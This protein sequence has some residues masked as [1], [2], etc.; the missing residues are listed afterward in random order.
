MAGGLQRLSRPDHHLLP[1]GR[2]IRDVHRH[3]RA[4]QQLIGTDCRR[5]GL[6][7]A[8]EITKLGQGNFIV[9]TRRGPAELQMGQRIA[10]DDAPDGFEDRPTVAVALMKS[11]NIG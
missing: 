5:I 4:G 9:R 6:Q 2:P 8:C 10:A 11:L 7:P 3:Q 1:L